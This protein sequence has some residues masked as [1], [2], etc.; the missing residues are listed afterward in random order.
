MVND[1]ECL[2]IHMVQFSRLKLFTGV[3]EIEQYYSSS[4]IYIPILY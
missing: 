1:A 3:T 4:T 2:V